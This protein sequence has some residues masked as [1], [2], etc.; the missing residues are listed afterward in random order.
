MTEKD[1]L[2]MLSEARKELPERVFEKTRFEIPK[3]QSFVEGKKTAFTNFSKIASHI[4]RE[5][6]H[7]CKFLVKE[8]GTGGIVEGGKLLLVGKFPNSLL[9]DK[10][11]KYVKEYVTCKECGK[12]DT[13][14]LKEDRI[15]F[16]KCEACGAK[17]PVPNV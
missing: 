14:L 4:N 16:L 7:F 15:L 8:L 13:L 11:A 5:E 6:S 2:K 12:Q 3:V 1:Y 10:V 9:N 17:R